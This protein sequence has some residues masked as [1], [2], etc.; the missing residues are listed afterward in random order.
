MKLNTY[1]EGEDSNPAQELNSQH[2][3]VALTA[4]ATVHIGKSTAWISG[5]AVA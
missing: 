4:L 3:H 1:R 2:L 5:H